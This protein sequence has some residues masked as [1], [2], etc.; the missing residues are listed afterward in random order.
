MRHHLSAWE[1]VYAMHA[2]AREVCVEV[3]QTRWR[4]AQRRQHARLTRLARYMPGANSLPLALTAAVL[5][6]RRLLTDLG[7]T[8]APAGDAFT[9]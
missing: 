6:Q 2:R 8:L 5:R 4:A 9:A 3:Q 7:P 1:K